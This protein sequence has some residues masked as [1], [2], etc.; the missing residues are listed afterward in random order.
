MSESFS[1][2]FPV[3]LALSIGHWRACF[4]LQAGFLSLQGLEDSSV[5]V[6]HT[7]SCPSML[8]W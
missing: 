6:V 1:I 2:H 5:S 7:G 3:Q 4:K 8:W